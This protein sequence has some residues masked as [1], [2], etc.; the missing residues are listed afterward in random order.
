[1][2]KQGGNN[3]IYSY[4]FLDIITIKN[5]NAFWKIVDNLSYNLEKLGDLYEKTISDSYVRES[6]LFDISDS[7]NILHIGCGAYP[8]TTITLAKFNGGNIVGIDKNPKAV[9]KAVEIVKTK[10]IENRVKI[11]RGDGI[12]YPVENFDAIIVSSCSIPKSKILEHLF[13]SAKPSCK[14]IIR[15]RFGPSKLVSSYIHEYN[16]TIKLV[17]RIQNYAFP[18]FRWD[19]FYLLKK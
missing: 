19:S 3:S 16:D 12:S 11:E 9:E 6:E 15:E 18:T 17:N 13:T 14:I 8:I 7:K 2:I 1:M 10:G 5:S 4:N